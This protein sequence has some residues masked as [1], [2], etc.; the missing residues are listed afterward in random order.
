MLCLDTLYRV[1]NT[2]LEIWKV[3]MCY[4]DRPCELVCDPSRPTEIGFRDILAAHMFADDQLKPNPHLSLVIVLYTYFPDPVL[5]ESLPFLQ[6]S[7]IE[8]TFTMIPSLSLLEQ[9]PLRALTT[10]TTSGTT[11]SLSEGLGEVAGGLAD[12]R[13][14]VSVEGLEIWNVLHCVSSHR[15]SW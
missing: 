14:S 8:N 10:S 3:C 9:R 5:D 7:D 13:T 2:S 1:W 11:E 15:P 12:Q 4:V 6:R